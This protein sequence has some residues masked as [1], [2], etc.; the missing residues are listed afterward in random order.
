MQRIGVIGTA[1]GI[2]KSRHILGVNA[3]YPI[4]GNTT[5]V[6]AKPTTDLYALFR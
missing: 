6:S 4:Q 1:I 5:P 3:V 2:V